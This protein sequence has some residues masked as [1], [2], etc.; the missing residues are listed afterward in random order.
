MTQVC[1]DCGEIGDWC[2]CEIPATPNQ[3]IQADI[4]HAVGLAMEYWPNAHLGDRTRRQDMR[5]AFRMIRDHLRA[6]YSIQA[7]CGA[8]S[9][10]AHRHADM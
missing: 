8:V 1:K 5:S 7:A 9:L 3:A 10:D 4:R 6:G 2:A